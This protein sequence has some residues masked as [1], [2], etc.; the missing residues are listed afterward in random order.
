M[1]G[2]LALPEGDGTRPAVLVAHE[3]GGL[4]EYQKTRAERFAELGYVAF[5]LDYHGL[6]RPLT[7]E[8]DMAAR[9][10]ALWLEPAR[11]RARAGGRLDGMAAA[12][13]PAP[14]SGAAVRDWLSR[15]RALRMRAGGA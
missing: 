11:L 5:A 4:D 13:T 12:P 6:G 8:E 10:H 7:S 15:R 3:G 14:A 2:R 9:C 1:I